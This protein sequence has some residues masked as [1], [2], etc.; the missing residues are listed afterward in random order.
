[1]IE[2][3]PVNLECKVET[4]IVLGSNVLFL[5]EVACLHIDKT[6][7]DK[8]GGV[9]LAKAEPIMFNLTNTYWEIGEKLAEYGFTESA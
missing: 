3:C 4:K 5:G 2:E 9:N 7:L 1:M 8:K 6:V